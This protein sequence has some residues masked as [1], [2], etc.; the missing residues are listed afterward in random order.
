MMDN[1]LSDLDRTKGHSALVH[2]TEEP[3]MTREDYDRIEYTLTHW[4]DSNITI[5]SHRIIIDKGFEGRIR[6]IAILST[7]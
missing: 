6:A 4:L 3:D 5:F 1:P 7:S 2:V